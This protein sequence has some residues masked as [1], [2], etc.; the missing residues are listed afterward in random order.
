MTNKAA[1]SSS[2]A[3]APANAPDPLIAPL[4]L[5]SPGFFDSVVLKARSLRLMKWST[6]VGWPRRDMIGHACRAELRHESVH[7]I[8]R[9]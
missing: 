4:V 6:R 7:Y 8:S 1:R 5:D 2:I 9:G 3:I